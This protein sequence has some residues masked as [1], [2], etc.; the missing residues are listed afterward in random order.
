MK[1]LNRLLLIN[2]LSYSFELLDLGKITFLTG[3]NASGK[4]T[5]IDAMQLVMLGDTSGSFFNKAANEKSG[6]TLESYLYGYVPNE[7]DQSYRPL[8]TNA[9]TSYVVLEFIDEKTT[10]PF[11]IGFV[12]D[13][14]KESRSRFRYRWFILRKSGI[15]SN[16]FIGKNDTPLSIKELKDM[17]DDLF[18]RGRNN[19][20]SLFDSS[21]DFR[22]AELIA[23]GNLQNQYQ[24]ILRKAVSFS[25]I[26]NIVNFINEYI[27]TVQNEISIESMQESIRNYTSLEE[28]A[29]ITEERIHALEEIKEQFRRFSDMRKN[30]NLYTYFLKRVKIEDAMDRLAT[31]E[32]SL[33]EKRKHKE[34]NDAL[35]EDITAKIDYMTKELDYL[36]EKKYTSSLNA[37]RNELQREIARLESERSGILR[38]IS[39]IGEGLRKI[40]ESFSSAIRRVR[41]AGIIDEI[42]GESGIAS[43][44]MVDTHRL[45]E[46]SYESLSQDV[47]AA[48]QWFAD[49][50]AEA[51]KELEE[52]REEESSRRTEIE[53]LEKGI[54][55][56]PQSALRFRD[57]AE[58]AFGRKVT[59]LADVLEVTDP[60]YQNAAEAYL[61]ER[62]FFLVLKENERKRAREILEER[63][64]GTSAGFITPEDAVKM[65][66]DSLCSI[67]SSDDR[68]ALA[69]ASSIFSPLSSS[70]CPGLTRDS[71]L[72]TIDDTSSLE[73]EESLFLGRRAVAEM[74]E[75]R[76][77]ELLSLLD[78]RQKLSSLQ[79][80]YRHGT[81][82]P[83]F[84]EEKASSYEE[85]SE[86]IRTLPD[87][88][89]GI[90]AMTEEL[91]GLDFFQLDELDRQISDAEKRKKEAEK[92]KEALI[93]RRGGIKEEIDALEKEI[94]LLRDS[95]DS[96]RTSLKEEYP[97]SDCEEAE[98]EFRKSYQGN[99]HKENA[100]ELYTSQLRRFTTL[101]ENGKESL[102]TLR[103]GYNRMYHSGLNIIAEDNDEYDNE[104][105]TLSGS[106]LPEYLEKIKSAKE[107]A[108]R[109]FKN[110][111]LNKMSDN[112][113]SSELELSRFNRIL[114]KYHFGDDSYEFSVQAAKGYEQYYRMFTSEELTAG[115]D[116]LFSQLFLERYQKELD[117]LFGIL[118]PSQ[119]S[120]NTAEKE[121]TIRKYI[122]YKTYLSFDLKVKSANGSQNL[123]ETII[124][125]SGGEVQIPFYISVLASF[126]QYCRIND[127]KH[128]DTVRLVIFDEAFSKMD[129]E[130]IRECLRLLDD[131][132]LQVVFSAPPEKTMDIASFTDRIIVAYKEDM[133]SYTRSFT[134]GEL[135][136]EKP[137]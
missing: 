68:T 28:T 93:E 13:C 116:S 37:R 88:E 57:A 112:I 132:D 100:V 127:E 90:A 135:R 20:F 96:L 77:K 30:K 84:D 121:K 4:S 69:Y 117:E 82:S 70:G 106:K 137:V 38:D 31:M 52:L 85:K 59:I 122:D 86:K 118:L 124:V 58:N 49:R 10:Y 94:P 8:R 66:E 24:R 98:A 73:D 104:L 2:W 114:S 102:V 16:C 129:G 87:I 125:K 14:P 34:R 63:F 7:S 21:K 74:L 9:F 80:A 131:F 48:K 107:S 35:I 26:T 91:Q 62:R 43:L 27:C 40:S 108:Y 113:K 47:T 44:S 65:R 54:K 109:Q 92:E 105:Q 128:S 119:N 75:R 76:K 123:S 18:D 83:S 12:A 53:N 32:A 51:R 72:T 89:D 56:Y 136:D 60:L 110:D 11:T 45:T 5:I 15:P 33:E 41:E 71:I 50:D 97:E 61:G 46:I 1:R 103:E 78:R 133:R 19:L 120:E 23:F 81:I 42:P 134:L 115:T 99:E 22:E 130:R 126:A 67:F 29:R 79:S 39:S 17:F 101:A 95:T 64:A 111:F 55:P 25:P 36:N 6:R 3:K